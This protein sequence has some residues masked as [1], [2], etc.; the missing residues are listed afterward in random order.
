MIHVLLPS[1]FSTFLA[2]I[3]IVCLHIPQYK[4]LISAMLAKICQDYLGRLHGRTYVA[5]ESATGPMLAYALRAAATAGRARDKLG[6]VFGKGL[7]CG[8][9]VGLAALCGIMWHYV[10]WR[11]VALCGVMWRNVALCGVAWRGVA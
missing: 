1:S 3:D 6:G 8:A 7:I 5:P 9:C 2:N 10:A 4:Q 11:Y